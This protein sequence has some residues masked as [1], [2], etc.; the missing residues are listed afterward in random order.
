M[1][2]LA[3]V[4]G[5]CQRTP[6]AT[7]TTRKVAASP[8]SAGSTKPSTTPEASATP[9][10][11][12]LVPPPDGVA[13]QGLVTVDAGYILS[14]NSSSIVAN[15]SAGV[16]TLG[17]AIVSDHG[18][19]IVGN[20]GG[21]LISDHGGGLT[22]KVKWGLL[23]DPETPLGTQLPVAGIAIQVVSMADGQPLAIMR[24]DTGN[25]VLTV[26]SDAQGRYMA[27]VP[28]DF[29]GN[30][31]VE[32]RVPGSNDPRLQLE[33]VTAPALPG[34]RSIDEE[35]AQTS[36]YLRNA[37][38]NHLRQWITTTDISATVTFY[39]TTWKVPAFLRTQVS[40]LIQGLNDA[41]VAAGVPKASQADQAALAKRL[42]D[43]MLSGIDLDAVQVDPSFSTKG[44]DT[45]AEGAVA[46][47]R[48]VLI[49]VREHATTKLREDPTF[50]DHQPYVIAANAK[51]PPEQAYH[52]IAPGD[53]GNFIVEEFL[54]RGDATP[55][56][57][58]DQ[59][60]DVLASV[61]A[62]TD[63]ATGADQGRRVIT[64][65][66]SLGARVGLA[67]AADE[68]GVRTRAL[69]LLDAYAKTGKI[70]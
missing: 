40:E 43:I 67:M 59:V 6:V 41:A 27:Y 53:L 12:V 55:G 7:T 35:T 8:A 21:T 47:M 23:A 25:P 69:A 45:L 39:A 31:R 62:Q 32:A 9:R 26:A 29:K 46:G 48:A 49:S 56:G 16:L 52:L 65:T 44:S 68:D 14:N 42:S 50:L 54:V 37:F 63:A 17:G 60:R 36:R 30:V 51:L 22:G 61:G 64:A 11:L 66:K 1:L 57:T 28:K 24:D 58:L 19:G 4:A 38:T 70:P 5:A 18:S 33:R 3:L 10:K 13:L 20:N 2:A 15:N 34:D